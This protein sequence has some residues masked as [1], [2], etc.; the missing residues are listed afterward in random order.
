MIVIEAKGE[1]KVLPEGGISLYSRDKYIQYM[2][3]CM[4]LY[5]SVKKLNKSITLQA[6]SKNK[7]Y[8]LRLASN[9]CQSNNEAK[10]RN[11]NNLMKIIIGT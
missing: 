8:N 1:R 2:S 5:F 7:Y 11:S 10:T 6:K 9:I 3:L 4:Y